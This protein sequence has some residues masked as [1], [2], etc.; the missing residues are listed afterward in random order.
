MG[1]LSG[2][3]LEPRHAWLVATVVDALV[4]TASSQRDVVS[5]ALA[6]DEGGIIRAF[7]DDAAVNVLQASAKAGP[8]GQ[9]VEVTCSNVVGPI[10]GSTVQL[11]LSKNKPGALD[12]SDIPH[13]VSVSTV[14]TASPLSSLYHSLRSAYLPF[15]QGHGSKAAVDP[16]LLDL[17][18]ELEAG[19][20]SAIRGGGGA[21]A[22]QFNESDFSGIL[23]PTDEFQLWASLSGSRNVP[24]ALSLR[25]SEINSLFEPIKR[26]FASVMELSEESVVDLVEQTRDVLD[27]VWK[28]PG[29]SGYPEAYPQARMVHLLGVVGQAFQGYVTHTLRDVKLLDVKDAPY[30]KVEKRLRFAQRLLDKWEKNTLEMTKVLW[31]RAD[32][33]RWKGDPFVDAKLQAFH[34]RVDSILEMREIHDQLSSL[35][36][37]DETR[38]LNIDDV[39][40]PFLLLRP[41]Q[42]NAYS[43]P[44]WESAKDAYQ[45]KMVPIE[46]RIS[47]KLREMFA[48]V[49]IPSLSASVS[50]HGDR[51]AASMAQPH[52]VFRELQRYEGL[53][54]RPV[55]AKALKSEADAFVRLAIQHLGNLR[56][57]FDERVDM[58]LRGGKK[59]GAGGG[60]VDH[61]AWAVQCEKK[62]DATYATF[63]PILGLSLKGAGAEAMRELLGKQADEFSMACNDLKRDVVEFKNGQFKEWERSTKED[64]DELS[65]E[66]S[67]SVMDMDVVDGHVEVHYS[68]Q[69]IRLLREVRQLAAL[70][71]PIGSHITKVAD[72][73]KK[74]YKQGMVLKQVANFYNDISNQMIPCQKQM[75]LA[76]AV[77]FEKVL[78]EPKDSMGK[79]LS[80]KNITSLENY[81]ARLK[82]VADSLTEKNR[83]LRK[84]HAWMGEKVAALMDVDLIRG[85][86][87]WKEGVKELRAKFD[88]IEREGFADT[89]EWRLHW[90]HQ[91]YKA[92]E[93][94]FR[95][96]VERATE[97]LP[98][99]EVRLVF[100]Q[101]KLV[102]EPPLEDVRSAYYKELKKFLN[103]PLSF[104]G[105]TDA[106]FFKHILSAPGQ[107]ASIAGCYEKSEQLFT[108]LADEQKKLYEWVALGTVDLDEFVDAHLELAEDWEMNLKVLKARAKGAEKIPSEVKVDCYTISLLPAK[109]A[110]DEQMKQMHDVLVGSL[111]RKALADKEAVEQFMTKGMETLDVKANSVEEI[112]NA[113]NEARLLTGDISRIM[114]LRRRCE[115]KSRLLRSV[116]TGAMAAPIDMSALN[117][118]W[119]NFTQRLEQHEAH[120]Q[121]QTSML[122]GKIEKDVAEFRGRI[123]SFAARW[124]E[125]KPKGV[126]QGDPELTLNKV[127][128]DFRSLGDLIADAERFK[129]ECDHFGIPEP[130]FAELAAVKADIESTRESWGR[131][132]KFNTEKKE[133]MDRDWITFR[134]KAYELE[135]FLNGWF[136]AIKASGNRDSVAIL[137][138]QEVEKYRK[139]LPYLKFLRGDGWERNHWA[140][141]FTMLGL[142]VKGP[143]AVTAETLKLGH[144]LS[145]ADV[146]AAK[147][148]EIKHLHAQAQGEVTI[149]DAI[150]QMYVWGIDRK[151]ALTEHESQLGA[152]AGR[153]TALIKEWRDI[154]TEVGDFQSLVASL[155]ESPF[156]PPF[157]DDTAK[158]EARLF[159]LQ[160]SLHHLNTIQR[161]WVYLEPIF[162][163][164]A[165]PQEQ[166]RFKRVDDEFRNLM[167]GIRR[168]PL[169]VSFAEIP[170]LLDTLPPMAEQLERCQKALSDFLEEKRSHFP[171]FYF[172]G[173]DDL[174]EILGQAKNPVVIQQHLK[175]L[176]AGIHS[177]KF[178]EGNTAILAMNSLDGELVPLLQPVAIK[179]AVEEW[180]SDLSD[181]MKATLKKCLLDCMAKGDYL[182]Y[183]SQILSLTELI[184]FTLRC[185]NAILRGR[186]ELRR[187]H[188]ELS[189]QLAKF[190]GYET[191]GQ[192]VLSL[193]IKSLILDLIHNRD[194][195]EHV[196][197]EKATK[198]EDWAWSK[199]LRY[200]KQDSTQTA[201][202]CMSDAKFDYSYEYQG[203][204]PKLVYT[205]LSDKCYLTLTQGLH[206][207]YGGNP[208]GPAGTGK[209]ESVKALGQYLARQV[210]VFNCDEEFDFKSMG[211]IFTGLV[212]CGAWGCFDEFNRLEE[213]VLSAVSQQIQAIQLALK[214]G[215]AEMDFMGKRVNVD[216]NAGIFVTLNPAGKGY[217]GRSKLPDNLKAL[218]RSVVMTVPD[219]ELIAEVYLISEG[220]QHAADLGR[221]LVAV[222]V[223]AR[224]LLSPQQHYDWGL[225]ALKTVLSIGGKLLHLEKAAGRAL[226]ESMEATLLIR[227]LRVTTLPKLAFQDTQAFIDLVSD[228]FPSV[229]VSDVADARVEAAIREVLVGM[230]F[231]VVP[232]QVEKVLQFHMACSQRIGVI[233]VGPSGSGKT[234][235]WRVLEAALKKL[236]GP[237]PP[238]I[239]VMNPK[240]IPR[241][242][243]L[244]HMD[245]DTREWTDGVLTAAARQVVK[246]DKEQH[247]WVICDGDVDPEWIESLNSVLDDNHLLTLPSG[248]RIQFGPNVNF[249]FECHSL[250]YASPATVSRA[251][252][253]FLSEENM[254]TSLLVK[255]WLA[256]KKEDTRLRMEPWFGDYF[257]KS[258]DW[259]QARK[260]ATETTKVGTIRSALSHLEG[261]SVTSKLEFIAGLYRGLGA[262]KEPT[263]RQALLAELCR[264][265]GESAA[266]VM[267]CPPSFDG[268][269]LDPG[270]DSAH[271]PGGMIVTPTMQQTMDLVMPW[272]VAG[273]P[274]LLVGPPG[275]GKS[276]L[277]QHCFSRLKSTAVATIHCSAQT[278]AANAV[279]K[280]MQACDQTQTTTGRVLRPRDA[281]KLVLFFKDIN[282]PKPDKY[283]TMQLVSFLQQLITYNGFYDDNRE[284]I[285]LQRIQIAASMNPATSVGRHHLT[286]RFTAVLGLAYM[287]Y[288]SR[289]EL[290]HVYSSMITA[291]LANNA[292]T[293]GHPTW[294]GAGGSG[295]IKRLAAC[296]LDVYDQMQQNFSS[297]EHRHYQFTPRNLSEW[298]QSLRRYNFREVDLLEVVSYEGGRVFRDRMVGDDVARCEGLLASTI[299]SAFRFQSTLPPGV[300]TTLAV[301][302]EGKV[303]EQGHPREMGRMPMADF[304]QVVAAKLQ[305]YERENKDLNMLLF[306]EILERIA[307][308]DRVLSQ[309][310][311]SLLLNGMSGVGRRT[312]ALLVA[313]M[314]RMDAFSP[315]MTMHYNLKAFQTDLKAVM[316]ATGVEGKQVMLLLEDH[317][318][319]EASFLELVN[320]VLSGGEVPGLFTPEELR[321]ALA[322][323]QELM[324]SEGFQ[325]R[326]L[327]SFFVSRV[328]ANLHVVLSM[329]P[330][331]PLYELRCESNPALFT[332]CSVQWLG[333][334]QPSGMQFVPRALLKDTLAISGISAGQDVDNLIGNFVAIHEQCR[335]FGAT[336]AQFVSLIR[337]Y[338]KILVGE[339]GSREDNM[340]RLQA[341]LGKLTEAAS[342]VDELSSVAGKQS[343][344]LADKQAEAERAL[345]QITAS[346]QKASDSK[347]E[348][349]K[350]QR[351]LAEEEVAMKKK[352]E[353]IDKELA[354]VQPMIDAARKAVG[355]IK[356]DNLN[357]IR[358]LKMPPDAIRDVLEGVLRIMG[359][360]DTSWVSMKKFLGQKAV[361]DDILNFD[362]SR[363]TPDVRDGIQKFLA[364]KANSFDHAVIYRVS[365]AAAPLAAWVKAVVAY[366]VVLEKT[367]PL[368]RESDRLARSLKESQERLVQC[369]DDLVRLDQ[370]VSRLKADFAKRT[371]EAEALK[372][373]LQKA[374]D[375]L[376]AAESLL[377]KLSGERVRWHKQVTEL[378]TE[379]GEMPLNSLLAAAFIVYLPSQQEKFRADHLA[380]W[381]NLLQVRSFAFKRFMSSESQ[382]L[383]WKAEGLPSDDLS[384]ENAI[385][386]LNAASTPLVVDPSTR[387]SSWLID[388]IKKTSS[389]PVEVTTLHD[390]RFAN[391]LEL[392]VRF[393]KCLIIQEV[394][395]IPAI[396]YPLLRRDF[397]HQGPR[398]TVQIGEKSIDFNESFGLFLVTRDPDPDL[399]PD[400]VSLVSM[401]NFTVTRSGLQGQ[402]LGLTIQHEQP[403][404]E[405]QKSELLKTEEEFK[406]Q[407]SVLEKQLLNELALSE[408]NIL[409]NKKLI[410]SLEETKSKSSVIEDSL[411]KSAELQASL[412]EKRNAYAPIASWGSTMFFLMRD[413]RAV[414]H[415]Y[416]F[417]LSLFL[418]LFDKAL[419]ADTPGLDVASRIAVLSK[420]LVQLLFGYVARSLFKADRLTFGL[421]MCQQLHGDALPPGEWDVLLG[422]AVVDGGSSKGAAPGWIPSSL[423]G[424]YH[425]IAAALPRLA[426]AVDLGNSDRWSHW[427]RSAH[428]EDDF[429]ESASSNKAVTPFHRLLLTQAFRPD[430]LES[431]MH[432]FVCKLLGVASVSPPPFSLERVFREES[433]PTEPVLFITSPGADP[434]QELEDF[435]DKVVGRGRFH[436]VAMGQGQTEQAL[437]LLRECAQSG[438]WL[439]LKNVHLVVGWLPTLEKEVFA[440][441]PHAEFRLWLSSEPHNKFPPSLLENCLKVTY[442][443]PPGLKKNLLRTYDSWDKDFIASGSPVRA[444]LLF[445]LAWFH[446][447]VQER[448]SYIPQGWSQFYEFSFADLRSGTDILEAATRNGAFPQWNYVHGLLENA[449]YGGRVDNVFDVR[450]LR[451]YLQQLFSPTLIAEPGSRV[452]TRALPGSGGLMLPTS[453]HHR[454]YMDLIQR[455]PEADSPSYFT[456]PAN[457]DRAAQQA[458]GEAVIRQLKAMS[459]STSA[460]R[461]FDREQWSKTLAP[462]LKV[463]EKLGASHPALKE[464]LRP[465]EAAA[466]PGGTPVDNF[467]LMERVHGRSL[468]ALLDASLKGIGDVLA[469]RAMLSPAIQKDAQALLHNTVPAKWD[470]AWEAPDDDNPLGYVR[471]VMA[472]CVA[473]EDWMA[474]VKAGK[475]LEGGLDLSA[476]FHP[477][478]FLNALRQQTARKMKVSMDE[479]KLATCFNASRLGASA[480]T[481][482]PVNIKGL[483]MQGAQFDGA[484]LSELSSDSPSTSEVPACIVMWIQKKEQFPYEGGYLS[485]PLYVTFSRRRLL[486]EVQLPCAEDTERWVLNG[487]ALFLSA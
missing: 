132:G 463:W 283:E 350:L 136:E 478:T 431:A 366:S 11:V 264:M 143:E 357:E 122:K 480:S 144:F 479:L 360:N 157:K 79:P 484:R 92:L 109:Q 466:K 267:A 138:L 439:C 465:N 421:H 43:E 269:L 10:A 420:E 81:I 393:G 307:K 57:D 170:R 260:D 428:C 477:G 215:A 219:N 207:G 84:W 384:M 406:V 44:L 98:Q 449:I 142:Q 399:P 158:W 202:V 20:G 71:F 481:S 83:R 96:G 286:S 172:I 346:M 49:L 402:L 211:R 27:A 292:S 214:E 41:L 293:Q 114:Q 213:D 462:I 51:S 294:G 415:M 429:P 435:A 311:G 338:K 9:T 425:M 327:F 403:E 15:L 371:G 322:P 319:L 87:K 378:Q 256:K 52:Q 365:V 257:Y 239:H 422:N 74:F 8:D 119:D 200:Y 299:R 19:L 446:A 451:T 409:E 349:E 373:N 389:S 126:P 328:R 225:R 206:L 343:K 436:Q 427:S 62:V 337:T 146:I 5:K 203:N 344:L 28:L 252:M 161:K 3:S 278:S 261:P 37:D 72:T 233:L 367:E 265:S 66:N 107:A 280:L 291:V 123:D 181:M 12:L 374:Q 392:A 423:A 212:K 153:K 174:L 224:Q 476:L 6:Q 281:E 277:L 416:Q 176:F 379:L 97:S 197:R 368:Q 89:R 433:L 398:L 339:R 208:Y 183:P 129:R 29:E 333:T 240:A 334:W 359:N 198:K 308:F 167:G 1:E 60:V 199:Q 173:D 85:R 226:D 464:A 220:F 232:E 21:G 348:V 209:T 210:L 450:V 68:G 370:D 178:N 354:D 53:L 282:L 372:I 58:A 413:L 145:K 408:G 46:G 245:M 304:E 100:K 247:S 340:K 442:E 254:H 93:A 101:K 23:T 228:V 296:M 159:T 230:G 54:A 110:I 241:Q 88:E 163:R 356:S 95:V 301:P 271:K 345:T 222:F 369:Q 342:K 325:H 468:V 297:N 17:I 457:I 244:G 352:S 75:M 469:G 78:R 444:Q 336:P 227:A 385:V 486:T 380:S 120:L 332:R 16:K 108:R 151:F 4:G 383:T 134:A 395:A 404:L 42:S 80:W 34:N 204:A 175:K 460:E 390:P 182:K 63:A 381:A 111:R 302:Q 188:K 76:D 105:V 274:F 473:L 323:L 24:K 190:A 128:D 35:L 36:S 461:S 59:G 394:D 487:A 285:G 65:L 249:I 287:T 86:D 64:L 131:Y 2:H 155:K 485:V 217:G 201:I 456:L 82:G 321:G 401:T 326:N 25:A 231:E 166:A 255:A 276:V 361:K 103:T 180:L 162:G 447:V 452:K 329:D 102:F 148:D 432:I 125:L 33:H 22:G 355:G 470:A 248:E 135:D 69:L 295:N 235:L 160:E 137:L 279:Q 330:R 289:E 419:N 411:R 48:S 169:V 73:A 320:S 405:T 39:F 191:D 234:T 266:S 117:S 317:Q 471:A 156:F 99:T 250:K 90:D 140:Q 116:A 453:A 377:G 187:L 195:L 437:M 218:F 38:M 417:S 106:D 251:G 298:A 253:I 483:V 309:P 458:N 194:V 268:E 259:A 454:D 474:S 284:F 434:S 410:A 273:R 418:K 363:I 168:D 341:G 32:G 387:A 445:V 290:E 459:V 193:K 229:K 400:A 438:D 149:R 300:F 455:L 26:P 305:A 414:N 443:A 179:E 391:T 67:A 196:D 440:L 396:L 347:N 18:A 118:G 246:E 382:M 216:K 147:A 184:D 40:A 482:I 31:P 56:K 223:L 237:P 324:A 154:L 171:R 177:V 258:M 115:E 472:R 288:A 141:L 331:N 412:D 243:L 152:T 192:H 104:K 236:G 313:H 467:V 362:A 165:L 127:E 430:R 205:P 94:Q 448:R 185:E 388:H 130:D 275:C 242:Q 353:E 47:T 407:L 314:H 13:N 77:N 310:G 272:L 189:E 150:N 186:D 50:R 263:V 316:L 306:P 262:N 133:M 112:G 441:R 303:F 113:R 70:G 315:N 164:G 312:T 91:L 397:A 364:A 238:R 358:S 424:N 376:A 318:L 270:E 139:V 221:K 335:G 45:Q 61:V 386:L 121:E 55:I 375:Q 475:L 124:Q 14:T 30:K 351:R 426:Q 7:L